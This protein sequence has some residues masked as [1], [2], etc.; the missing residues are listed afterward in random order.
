ME[1]MKKSRST[2]TKL[3]VSRWENGCPL[4][5]SIVCVSA[6]TFVNW[7]MVERSGSRKE[8][9]FGYP[10]MDSILI[11][12][13]FL[14]QRNSIRRD[15]VTKTKARLYQAHIFHLVWD[16]GIASV[17]IIWDY[18]DSNGSF[19]FDANFLSKLPTGSRF[20]LLELKVVLYYILLHFTIVPNAKSQIPL[21]LNKTPFLLKSERGVHVTLS[22]RK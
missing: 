4:L 7:I 1:P 18:I 10:S 12:T 15:S 13:S 11:Q 9:Y 19:D 6:I 2:W 17:N 5:C 16:P 20:A 8:L 21:Q 14:S 22:P 3:Y